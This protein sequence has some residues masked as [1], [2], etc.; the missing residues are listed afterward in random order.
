MRSPAGSA[1]PIVL[2][3]VAAGDGPADIDYIASNIS[4]LAIRSGRIQA[5]M[6][7]T[8]QRRSGDDRRQGKKE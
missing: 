4:G 7:G 2:L 6:T 3:G 1:G 5:H 8:R